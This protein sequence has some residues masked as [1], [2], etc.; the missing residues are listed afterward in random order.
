MIKNNPLKFN[1]LFSTFGQGFKNRK[2]SEN[3]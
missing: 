3:F 1:E 2:F